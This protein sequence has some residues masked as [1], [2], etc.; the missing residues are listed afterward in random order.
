MESRIQ[1]CLGYLLHG[2]KDNNTSHSYNFCVA[3]SE[4][5]T[6]P[7]IDN[8]PYSTGNSIFSVSYS[9]VFSIS[10]LD[11]MANGAVAATAFCCDIY[12]RNLLT[13]SL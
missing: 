12:D 10:L 3:S 9:E 5:Q 4:I 11:L 13:S 1:D 6:L 8:F 2:A 7:K